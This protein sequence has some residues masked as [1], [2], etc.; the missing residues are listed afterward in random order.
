MAIFGPG[1]PRGVNSRELEKALAL[2]WNRIDDRFAK[3]EDRAAKVDDRLT[4]MNEALEQIRISVKGCQDRLGKVDDR[5][6]K[7]DDELK[8]IRGA[9]P[10]QR[11]RLSR[12]S[13]QRRAGPQR[14]RL[15]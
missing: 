2:I 9:D 10:H 6:N 5:F 14:N 1:G 7:M 12:P 4:K 8:Q 15:R 11:Q 3:A 13:R